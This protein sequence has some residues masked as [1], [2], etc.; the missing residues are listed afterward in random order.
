MLMS[1]FHF[2]TFS[3]YNLVPDFIDINNAFFGENCVE[4]G[5]LHHGQY[6]MNSGLFTLKALT[7]S[8][9]L[10]TGLYFTT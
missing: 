7:R 8:V 1:C 4:L 2:Y 6:G 3:Y 9:K 5:N 10:V